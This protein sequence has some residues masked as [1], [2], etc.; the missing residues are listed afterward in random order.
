[1]PTT[2]ELNKGLIAI[3]E[4]AQ[5]ESSHKRI[6]E[7]SIIQMIDNLGERKIKINVAELTECRE[8]VHFFIQDPQL[9]DVAYLL[10]GCFCVPQLDINHIMYLLRVYLNPTLDLMSVFDQS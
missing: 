4:N 2:Q 3:L 7:R 10:I 1:M 5:I 6:L 9:R 8:L